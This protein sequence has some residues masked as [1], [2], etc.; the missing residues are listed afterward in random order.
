MGEAGASGPRTGGKVGK[1]PARAQRGRGEGP[2]GTP[3]EPQER[4]REWEQWD[5]RHEGRR[6]ERR[7]GG[8]GQRGTS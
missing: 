8:I 2:Q 7:P 6:R 1:S 3:W 4:A 5:D